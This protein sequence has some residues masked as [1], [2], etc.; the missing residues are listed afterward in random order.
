LSGFKKT[1]KKDIKILKNLILG[2]KNG[3]DNLNNRLKTIE[4][5]E[6]KRFK[7]K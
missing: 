7:L 6:D 3:V 4:D 1:N 2:L 5:I